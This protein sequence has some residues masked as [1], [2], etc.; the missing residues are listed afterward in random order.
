MLLRVN[1]ASDYFGLPEFASNTSGVKFHDNPESWG[2]VRDD[3]K[4]QSPFYETKSISKG[5]P[6]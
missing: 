5:I 3:S 1:F 6:A 2:S 4:T